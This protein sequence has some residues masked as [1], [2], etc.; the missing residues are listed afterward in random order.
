VTLTDSNTT[1]RLKFRKWRIGRRILAAK[2]R[3]LSRLSDWL[4][5][6]PDREAA[7]A[8]QQ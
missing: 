5:G 1:L 6:V 7:E 8:A 3:E 2:A 4:N